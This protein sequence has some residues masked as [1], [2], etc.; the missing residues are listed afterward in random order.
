MERIQNSWERGMEVEMHI[1]KRY[2][3]AQCI[4]TPDL[5]LLIVGLELYSHISQRPRFWHQLFVLRCPTYSNGTP[6]HH[7]PLHSLLQSSPLDL[8]LGSAFLGPSPAAL[9]STL[10]RHDY[11]RT[12]V[13]SWTYSQPLILSF[14][15][16][17]RSDGTSNVPAHLPFGQPSVATLCYFLIDP[18][19]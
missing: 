2:G 14:Q 9:R 7:C 15:S 3:Q 8:R 6:W 18:W 13:V 5:F 4:Y 16:F 11:K 1:R 10:M 19:A 12:D 17:P